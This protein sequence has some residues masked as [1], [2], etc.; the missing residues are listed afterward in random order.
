ME[1]DEVS[2]AYI[3][4]VVAIV[5]IISFIFAK[6]DNKKSMLNTIGLDLSDSAYRTLKEKE[7]AKNVLSL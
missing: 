6:A 5:V 2:L 4:I 7:F 1:E 3:I